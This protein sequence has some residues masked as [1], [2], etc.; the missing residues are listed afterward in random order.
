MIAK[1]KF[2]GK[3]VQ[4][5]LKKPIDLSLASKSNASFKAWFSNEISFKTVSNNGFTGSVNEGGAV[6]FREITI[7]PHANMTHSESVGHISSEQV[8]VNN[9]INQLNVVAQLIS[10]SPQTILNDNGVHKKG[11]SCVLLK[12][13]ENKINKNVKALIIRT[14]KNYESL[15]KKNYSNTNWPYLSEESALYIRKMGIKHLLIDQPS[16]DREFDSGMLLAHKAFWNFYKTIDKE[17]TITELIGVPNN[18]KDGIYL[19][20]LTIANIENDASPS[21]PVIYEMKFSK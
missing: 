11:D 1:I 9:I 6:N 17:R 20:S 16:I 3:E 15:E 5:D 8:P 13:L 19:L 12:Q 2:A 10:I 18:V 4:V 14:Q 7:N 21:R